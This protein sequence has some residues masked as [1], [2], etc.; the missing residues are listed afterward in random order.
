MVLLKYIYGGKVKP[1]LFLD[2]GWFTYISS[3]RLFRLFWVVGN[4]NCLKAWAYGLFST[5]LCR[6][7]SLLT[8][9][10][11][12]GWYILG[13]CSSITSKSFVSL[14]R[15]ILR[16][17]GIFSR[18]RSLHSIC[19]AFVMLKGAWSMGLG[20]T[21]YLFLFKLIVVPP[22]IWLEPPKALKANKF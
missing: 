5:L 21:N 2:I 3:L 6:S 16:A 22:I 13:L 7:W 1:T 19:F 17:L 15:G 14:N 11:K 8:F 10:F 9:L 12:N 18:D 20:D 4:P